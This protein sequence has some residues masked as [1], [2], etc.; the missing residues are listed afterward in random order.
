MYIQ[1]MS[2]SLATLFLAISPGPDNLFVLTQSLAHGKK[3]G[4]AIVLGLLSGCVVH[5]TLLAFGVSSWITQYKTLFFIIKCLGA[6]YLFFLAYQ[7]LR[8]PA[9]LTLQTPSQTT[10]FSKLYKQGVLMNLLNPKV[11]LFFLAFF[12]GFLWK[13]S[14]VVLQFYILGLVFI[15]VSFIV[16]GSIAVFAAALSK[17][18]LKNPYAGIVLKYLQV[19]VFVGIGIYIL[20]PSI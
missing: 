5:T 1:L 18:L 9:N 3:Q 17:V 14:Q 6:A 13:S 8:H 16:F 12:P 11:M 15:I 4:I 7:V 20:L 10:K 19:F 2:F